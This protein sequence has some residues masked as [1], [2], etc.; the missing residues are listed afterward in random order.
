MEARYADAER[1]PG[2][3]AGG[4]GEWKSQETVPAPARK[5]ARSEEEDDAPAAVSSK[6]SRRACHR[7]TFFFTESDEDRAID[8]G[9]S[10]LEVTRTHIGVGP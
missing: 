3:V 8:G 6:L 10:V 5:R 4:G 9:G 7:L 1:G 2:A